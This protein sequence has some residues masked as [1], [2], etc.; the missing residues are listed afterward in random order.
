M[1]DVRCESCQAPYQ[2][3]E[4]RVPATGLRMRCP[5]CGHSFVVQRP[6]ASAAKLPVR[7]PS[8]T[9]TVTPALGTGAELKRPELRKRPKLRS[10]PDAEPSLP[11]RPPASVP[12]GMRP[13]MPELPAVVIERA[14][15]ARSVPNPP[16]TRKRLPD[17]DDSAPDLPAVPPRGPSKPT[18]IASKAPAFG[19]LDWGLDDDGDLPA[20]TATAGAPSLGDFLGDDLLPER[21][22]P[23]LPQRSADLPQRSAGLPQRAADLPQRGAELPQRADALPQRGA[24][25]PQRADALP[26]RTSDLPL[27]LDSLPVLSDPLPLVADVLP[28]KSEPPF[29][30]DLW[31][32][33]SGAAKGHGFED[34]LGFGEL[35]LPPLPAGDTP[36]PPPI[37]AP[38]FSLPNPG[39][40]S[41]PPPL[42][43]GRPGEFGE[44]DLGPLDAPVAGGGISPAATAND[45]LPPPPPLDLPLPGTTGSF[46]TQSQFIG[47]VG[48][49]SERPD[50]PK[51]RKA[52]LRNGLAMVGVALLLVGGGALELTELGAFG[53]H[54]IADAI[55][56]SSYTSQ[57]QARLA[58]FQNVAKSDLY[59]GTTA[60]SQRV[61]AAADASPRAWD[62]A[63]LAAYTESMCN[64]RFGSDPARAA[65]AQTLLSR[66][67]AHGPSSLRTLAEIASK[68]SKATAASLRGQLASGFGG[69]LELEAAL[70]DGELALL[71]GDD[72]GAA[73]TFERARGLGGGA[74]AE[75]GVARARAGT[76]QAKPAIDA[77]LAAVPEHAEA[78]TLLARSQVEAGDQSAA[79]ASL[80][81]ITTASAS[82][83]AMAEALAL[84][85]EL[86]LD[87]GKTAEA[88]A[89]F[90]EAF[91]LDPS[92]E[93]AL[94]GQ[95]ESFF[96]AGRFTEALARFEGAMKL[97]NASSAAILG[98]ART[99]LRLEATADAEALLTAAQKAHEKDPDIAYWLGEAKRSLGKNDDALVLFETAQKLYPKT[100]PSAFLP[101]AAEA[102]ILGQRGDEQKALAVLD[103]AKKALPA[104]VALDRA[105]GDLAA[106]GG[107]YD[108]AIGHY[109]SAVERAPADWSARLELAQLLRKSAKYDDAA[110][111][112]ATIAN[113][114]KDYPGLTLERGILLEQTGKLE[115]ALAE[116][117]T[118]LAT[119]PDD[120]DRVLR[121]GGAY[122]AVG[123]VDDAMPLLERVQKA[124]P[125]SAEAQHYLGR[126][127][128]QRGGPFAGD[129]LRLL[130]RAAELAPNNASFHVYV[131][132]AA[133]EASPPQVQI[134]REE[135][136]RAL[137]IDKQEADAYWQRGVA[138][139]KEGA[140]VSALDDL[141]KAVQLKPERAEAHA[142]LAECYE[143]QS[144]FG[145]AVVEW[146]N[147]IAKNPKPAYWRYRYGR[148]VAERGGHTESVAHLEYAVTEGEK[149]SVRPGWLTQAL[150]QEAQVLRRVGRT[151]D[152][153]AA[154]RNYVASAP[155]SAPDRRDAEAAIAALS[156][157]HAPE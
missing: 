118:A 72:A 127:K 22:T 45:A 41:E 70:L 52:R 125:D 50:D 109:R 136:E 99:K 58:G 112:L 119:A 53:R 69:G 141:K 42:S 44:L 67:A 57:V 81:Q 29:P 153:L 56:A 120:L 63:S 107:R 84:K 95:G 130:K 121:V 66:A 40:A 43:L 76:P 151:K 49:G 14:A 97:P 17:P 143:G 111:E 38:P 106:A 155:A 79:L 5:K 13:T 47:N 27:S 37:S 152:A 10:I 105:F 124:R 98:V 137:A 92:S 46:P 147:A 62:L 86:L 135:A 96:Q 23:D 75:Y 68:A 61:R 71:A 139:L 34:P 150:Y 39:A 100:S 1:L 25:L 77:I 110:R 108:V 148:L 6:A 3:D 142:A 73:T 64:L 132:W 154:F 33:E 140:F 94:L 4:R 82:P 8:P 113:A 87:G 60:E 16:I 89:A 51:A 103:E 90:D 7:S 128:L 35:E 9:G 88:R 129:A 83:R 102:K 122:L 18:P 19:E 131:A 65:R 28:V 134:A 115:E 101:Y 26:V 146:K 117:K 93:V 11:A 12:A 157:A 2:V 144:Q 59:A 123:R 55:N 54:R 138:F 114:D 74:R 78:R 15:A 32:P 116:F 126:A 91:R 48:T 145:L 24:E 36:P 30:A 85:G 149:A 104:S 156:G 80:G 21:S 31:P 20:P 133:N